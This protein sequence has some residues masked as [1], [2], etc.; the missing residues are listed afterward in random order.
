MEL[1]VPKYRIL[2]LY[3]NFAQFG[4][5]VFGVKAAASLY[6][7]IEPS[8]LSPTQSALLVAVLPTPSR[9]NPARP[10]VYLKERA[11][12][13]LDQMPRMGGRRIIREMLPN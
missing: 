5:S 1:I 3:M 10:S 7:G 2:E 9:S 12:H 6:Y 13:I 11:A 4:K 8:A